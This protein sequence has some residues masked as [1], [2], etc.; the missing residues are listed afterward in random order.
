MFE[1]GFGLLGVV[2]SLYFIFLCVCYLL[3]NGVIGVCVLFILLFCVIFLLILFVK[4][5]SGVVYFNVLVCLRYVIMC[6]VLCV[7]EFI[8]FRVIWRCSIFRIR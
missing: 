8:L 1:F 4:C 7:I 5:C 3:E 2:Y 6:V